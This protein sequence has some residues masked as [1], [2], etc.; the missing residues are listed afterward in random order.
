MEPLGPRVSS[1]QHDGSHF[2][3][4]VEVGGYRR[5]VAGLAASA[6]AD[7][8]PVSIPHGTVEL[9]SQQESVQPGHAIRLGLHFR[10]GKGW[11]IYWIENPLKK[12]T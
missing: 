6:I 9:L 11:H 10:L 8:R 4:Q 3:T 2:P 5:V 12:D 7:E 1:N